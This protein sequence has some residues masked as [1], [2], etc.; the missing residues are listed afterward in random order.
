MSSSDAVKKPPSASSSPAPVGCL[1]T[2]VA[3]RRKGY[4]V[5]MPAPAA[6]LMEVGAGIQIP[7]NSSHLLE[8]WGLKE[9]LK[10]VV[11][12]KSI[13]MRRYKNGDI[14]GATPLDPKMTKPSY[15]LT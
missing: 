13:N 7:P 1:A 4:A 15:V 3:L 6:L 14:I 2:A 5:H 10:K 8:S 12:P 9:L 11:W